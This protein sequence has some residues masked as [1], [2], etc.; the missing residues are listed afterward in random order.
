ML[1]DDSVVLKYLNNE[2]DTKISSHWVFKNIENG[3]HLFSAP[4]PIKQ[5]EVKN[6]LYTIKKVLS[7][8]IPIN[9][10][11]YSALYPQW[12]SIINDMNVLLLVG[13]PAPYDAMVRKYNG[14]V[15]NLISLMGI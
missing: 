11:I 1:I 10:S 5:Y 3:E 9:R 7:E 12:E 4:N 14:G 15:N 13:C 6:I 2:K 8:F